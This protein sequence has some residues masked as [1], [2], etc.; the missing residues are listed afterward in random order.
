MLSQPSPPDS[1]ETQT[2]KEIEAV[3]TYIKAYIDPGGKF[4]SK[5]SS[6]GNSLH[7][8]NVWQLIFT[9][10]EYYIGRLMIRHRPDLFPSKYSTTWVPTPFIS[11]WKPKDEVVLRGNYAQEQGRLFFDEVLTAFPYLARPTS[12]YLKEINCLFEFITAPRYEQ[13]IITLMK[14]GANP[15]IPLGDGSNLFTFVPKYSQNNRY[16]HYG[17]NYS[18]YL[19]NLEVVRKIWRLLLICRGMNFSPLSPL[20]FIKFYEFI[21]LLYP[22]LKNN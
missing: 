19:S 6:I 20:R 9:R 5:E 4:Y 3:E 1:I 13:D 12:R 17:S 22:Y 18:H 8:N 16:W 15:D 7:A 11:L 14:H 2:K 10:E 21:R